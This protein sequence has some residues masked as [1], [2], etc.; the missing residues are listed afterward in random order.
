M[1]PQERSTTTVLLMEHE[2]RR[3]A[4]LIECLGGC[5]CAVISVADPHEAFAALE[6]G[7][8]VQVVVADIDVPED[9]GLPFMWEVHQRWPELGLVITSGRLRHMR[10]DKVPGGGCFIPRP[11]PAQ[12]LVD[13]VQVAALRNVHGDEEPVPS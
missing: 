13:L 4:A 2:P 8:D 9:A 3:R 12:V 7:R 1:L 6:Q 10:P 5:G 11:I